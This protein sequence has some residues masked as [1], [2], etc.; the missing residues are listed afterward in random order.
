[1]KKFASRLIICLIFVLV[2]Q[3]SD[4]RSHD[5][6]LITF[7]GAALE[8]MS[9]EEFLALE[10]IEVTLTRTN[11][12]GKTT[13]GTYSGVRWSVL[14]EAIGAQDANS[15]RVI[16]SDGFEQAYAL[17]VLVAAGS[18]FALLKDGGP[19]TEEETNGQLWF[20]AGEDYT[21]N[22]WTKYIAKIVVP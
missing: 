6:R 5:R 12:K 10:Q 13:V 3:V 16:A 2:S 11:S 15:I 20:C 9:R 19:L 18:L 22:F 4:A 17:D 8:S 21:A 1:M 14:A 7:E